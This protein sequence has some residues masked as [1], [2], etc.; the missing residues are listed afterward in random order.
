MGKTRASQETIPDQLDAPNLR[1][2][3]KD[4][5]HHASL[6]D[7]QEEQRESWEQRR[8]LDSGSY[9]G[10]VFTS[11]HCVPQRMFL[12]PMLNGHEDCSEYGQ[13]APECSL[14]NNE[15]SKPNR[16]SCD[17]RTVADR[18]QHRRRP[19]QQSPGSVAQIPRSQKGP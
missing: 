17:G 19:F 15:I 7:F 13:I 10:L 8:L 5:Y 1:P 4:A 2:D 9:V 16:H 14:R 6:Q 3:V 12:P 11:P 18:R